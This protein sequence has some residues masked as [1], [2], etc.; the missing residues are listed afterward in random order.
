LVGPALRLKVFFF[1]P[2]SDVN[3]PVKKSDRLGI[4]RFTGLSVNGY[5]VMAI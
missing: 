2:A 4:N 3:T 1:S 5:F